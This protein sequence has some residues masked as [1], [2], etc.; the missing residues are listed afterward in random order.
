MYVD[1]IILT[2]DY[3]E[4][5]LKIKRS[6]AKEFEVKDLGPLRYFLGMEVAQSQRGIFVS[7]RKN[8]LDLLKETGMLWCKPASTP[9]DSKRKL[10]HEEEGVPV[11]KG[12]Y[13]RLVG[14]LIYLAHTQHDIGFAVSVVSQFMNHP[15]EEHMEAVHRILSSGI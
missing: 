14:K 5:L 2:R 15:M 7:Q 3:E 9:M 12:R 10:G 11:D 4:E 13:Q 8:I 1:D 6:L